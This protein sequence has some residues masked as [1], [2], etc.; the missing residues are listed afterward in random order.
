MTAGGRDADNHVYPIAW[1]VID[2]ENKDNWTCF[3]ELL[4][5]DLDL[6]CSRGL[7]VISDQHKVNYTVNLFNYY[8]LIII[9]LVGLL[10]VGNVGNLAIISCLV[11]MEKVQVTL[12]LKGKMV[13]QRE[14]GEGIQL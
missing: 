6:D 3:I 2:V 4:V 9:L 7:V 14:M 8:T 10:G 13:D 5:A 11:R 1:A 12:S